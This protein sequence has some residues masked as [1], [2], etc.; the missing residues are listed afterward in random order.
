MGLANNSGREIAIEKIDN[1]SREI[2]GLKDVSDNQAASTIGKSGKP[3]CP[4]F[5]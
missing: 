5:Q 4:V 3:V 2:A 1:N